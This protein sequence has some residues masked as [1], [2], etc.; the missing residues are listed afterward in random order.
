[1]PGN[2]DPSDSLGMVNPVGMF[3]VVGGWA[4]EVGERGT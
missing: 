4:T 1:M 2:H 3:R